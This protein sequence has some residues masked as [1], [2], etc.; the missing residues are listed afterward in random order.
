MNDDR[1]D[2]DGPVIGGW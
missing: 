2:I 1:H